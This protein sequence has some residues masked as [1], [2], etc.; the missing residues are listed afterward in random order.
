MLDKLC[1]LGLIWLTLFIFDELNK[2]VFVIVDLVSLTHSFGEFHKLRLVFVLIRIN[3][4]R[5]TGGL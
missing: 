4:G 1:L 3:W 2:S 5:D